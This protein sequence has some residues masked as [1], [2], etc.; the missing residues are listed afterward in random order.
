MFFLTQ[1][2]ADLVPLLASSLLIFL[3]FDIFS[4]KKQLFLWDFSVNLWLVSVEK[5]TSISS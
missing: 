4:V 1:M 3:S 2:W 5:A